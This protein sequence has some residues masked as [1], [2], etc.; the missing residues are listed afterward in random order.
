MPFPLPVCTGRSEQDL[1][2]IFN[3]QDLYFTGKTDPDERKGAWWRQRF[4]IKLTLKV[5][6]P[7][8]TGNNRRL[9]DIF[10]HQNG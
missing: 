7:G 1:L 10:W 8:F 4:N 3:A 9:I 5:P 2:T 6:D